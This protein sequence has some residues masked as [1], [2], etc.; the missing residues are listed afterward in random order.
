MLQWLPFNIVARKRTG[1]IVVTCA[2]IMLLKEIRDM[3]TTEGNSD[4]ALE[5]DN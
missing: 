1:K 3:R 2:S 5:Q 4:T